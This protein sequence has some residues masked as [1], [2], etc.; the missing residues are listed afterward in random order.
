MLQ[1]TIPESEFFNE[2]TSEFVTSPAAT[3]RLEHSL[4]SLSKWESKWEKPFLSPDKKTTEEV[5]WYIQAMC[6]DPEV[7]SET[8]L[9]ITNDDLTKINSYIEA[10]MTATW[11]GDTQNAPGPRS[12]EVITAE[13]IYYWMIALNIPF[14]CQFWHINRL[15]TLIKVCNQK[16]APQKKMSR[17]DLANRNRQLNEARKAQF[18]TTG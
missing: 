16:N 13:V 1:I 15:F 18:N 12:R 4:V 17:R 7:P 6:L 2:S 14:E 9:R 3:L 11:F 5:R 10:K 8:F